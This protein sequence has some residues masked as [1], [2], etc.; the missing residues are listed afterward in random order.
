MHVR[1]KGGRP[2]PMLISKETE[3]AIQ[4]LIDTREIV[5]VSPENV[6]VFAAPTRKSKK[7]LRGSKCL[8]TVIGRIPS[9]QRPDLIKSTPLR[10]INHYC[11]VVK[12]IYL[13]PHK[14]LVLKQNIFSYTVKPGYPTRI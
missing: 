11:F 12:P 8:S 6:F 1:G 7:P 2:V 9:L 10:Y 13:P 3:T 5:G 4:L 14:R